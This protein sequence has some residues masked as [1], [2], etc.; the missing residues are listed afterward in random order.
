MKITI[1]PGKQIIVCLMLIAFLSC[2]KSMDTLVQ[3]PPIVAN[4]DSANKKYLALGDSYTIGQS[5]NMNERFPAQVTAQLRAAGIKLNEPEYIATTGWTTL[6]LQASINAQNPQGAYD[7]VSLLIGVNDQ[8]QTH[9]TTNYRNNF[10]Q[11]LNKSVAL[12]GNRK[13]RVFVVSIPD[14]SVT[15][16]VS[17]S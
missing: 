3:T 8:Y 14:Y 10:T 11:L 4:I 5:V 17:Q 12:A 2:S 13:E 1:S 16:F 7:A 6:N 15:P 9:D